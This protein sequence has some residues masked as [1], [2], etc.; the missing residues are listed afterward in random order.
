MNE[1]LYSLFKELNPETKNALDFVFKDAPKMLLLI[2]FLKSIEA[3]FRTQKAIHHL[4]AD[5]LETVEFNTLVNRY[6]KLRQPLIEWLY[7][8]FKKTGNFSSKDEQELDFLKYLVSKNQYLSTLQR[9]EA[10]EERCW[11]LHL[12][13]LLPEL[14]QLLI[15]CQQALYYKHLDIRPAEE[16]LERALAYYFKLKQLQSLFLS[17]YSRTEESDYLQI[18]NK[19]RKCIG[20]DKKNPRFQLIYHYTAFSRGIMVSNM[21]RKAP[22]VLT[23]HLNLVEKIRKESPEL[24]FVFMSLP[25]AKSMHNSLLALKSIFHFLTSNFKE[26]GQAVIEQDQLKKNN[27]NIEFPESEGGL[28]N[29][30]RIL[31]GAELFDLAWKKTLELELFYEKNEFED[32][33]PTLLFEQSMIHFLQFP[34][35]DKAL[36]KLHYQQITTYSAEGNN[37]AL[38]AMSKAFIDLIQGRLVERNGLECLKEYYQQTN[39]DL[40]VDLMESLSQNIVLKNR[41]GIK[42]TIQL[43]QKKAKEKCDNVDKLMY[44]HL[45][46]LAKHYL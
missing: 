44:K 3:P 9:G 40:D 1:E 25:R 13:E 46:K 8:F 39:N 16:R 20:A 45:I 26:A 43:M 2:D 24:P 28:R 5:E 32:K 19:I 36:I 7:H 21:I 29:S 35:T 33:K 27:P 34:N 41:L 6:H 23:R 38:L 31:I 42:A 30:I 18:L 4:Y 12:Y 15:F 10:L 37:A 14:L 11:K 22:H 17:G